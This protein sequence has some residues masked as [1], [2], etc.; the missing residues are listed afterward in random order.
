LRNKRTK[1]GEDYYKVDSRSL[2][3]GENA[4]WERYKKRIN[5]SH[6][7]STKHEKPHRDDML[8]VSK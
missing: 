7:K 3:R 4:E 1:K 5:Y 8:K 6:D 2:E